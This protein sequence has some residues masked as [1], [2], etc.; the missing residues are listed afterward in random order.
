MLRA[1]LESNGE[2]GNPFSPEQ[3]VLLSLEIL[4][5]GHFQRTQGDLSGAGWSTVHTLFYK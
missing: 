2:K 4:A 3:V 1:D 5:G